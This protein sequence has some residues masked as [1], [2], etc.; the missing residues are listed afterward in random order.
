MSCTRLWKKK[1]SSCSQ[2]TLRTED[3][4][5]NSSLR[6]KIE[7]TKLDVVAHYIMVHNEENERIKMSKKRYKPKVGQYSLNAGFNVL[8]EK[9]RKQ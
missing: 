9:G 1:K 3:E 2:L 7:E 8:E 6:D 5:K 4:D